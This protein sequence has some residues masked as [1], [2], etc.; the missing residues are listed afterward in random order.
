MLLYEFR[1]SKSATKMLQK[2]QRLCESPGAFV[3]K[4]GTSSKATIKKKKNMFSSFLGGISP[5]IARDLKA[6]HF[7]SWVKQGF[8][9]GPK[10]T[11]KK[12]QGRSTWGLSPKDL[13]SALSFLEQLRRRIHG[14][15]RILRDQLTLVYSWAPSIVISRF[16][17][18]K[19]MASIN[20][21]HLLLQ[22]FTSWWFQ[23]LWK[24]CS[25]NWESSP[26]FGVKIK[27]IC[28]ATNLFSFIPWRIH[29]I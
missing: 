2:S 15:L 1:S 25:S 27:K 29:L 6:F 28:E 16:I 13:L 5:I 10:K 11:Q 26:G 24:I 17:S 8:Q 7:F 4:W 19:A 14:D 21:I 22:R 3:S 20:V 12:R 18:C 9:R 23:P